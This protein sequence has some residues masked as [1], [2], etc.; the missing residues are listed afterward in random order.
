M[1]KSL[2]TILF[3]ACLLPLIGCAVNYESTLQDSISI[4]NDMAEV[5]NTCKDKASAEAAIPKL[6]SL[7]DDMLDL[8]ETMEALGKPSDEDQKALMEK[9]GKEQMKAN[10]RFQKAC[11]AV[12]SNREVGTALLEFFKKLEE[13]Q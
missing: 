13:L 5:L 6:E 8:K 2:P 11:G 9:Y 3:A 10:G 7:L 12:G 4:M 1:S